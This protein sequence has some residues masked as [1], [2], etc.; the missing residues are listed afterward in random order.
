[1]DKLTIKDIDV[2]GKKVLVR[3]DFNVPID[4]KTGK[5]SDDSRIRA[6]I[7]TIE[8]LIAHGAKVVL[9]SHMGRPDGKVVESM[10]LKIAA[11][12]LSELLNKP[13]LSAMDCIGSEVEKM[14]ADMKSGDMLMLENL[15]FHAEEEENEADFARAL[16]GLAD[17]YVDDAF[18]TVHRK[19]A[20][21]VGVTEHLPAVAGFL[22]EKELEYLG[23][24]IEN[25]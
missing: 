5:I 24:I 4:R 14:V 6:A 3:V 11:A 17:I 20:S 7:P 1:M 21:V 18:G 13:V 2:S 23:G 15:R 19:H 12:R 16:A 10:R 9:C 25:P 22:M 8:Y